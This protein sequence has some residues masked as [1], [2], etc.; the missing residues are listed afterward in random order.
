[1]TIFPRYFGNN[2]FIL[3]SIY[4][5]GLDI[6]ICVKLTLILSNYI[7]HIGMKLKVKNLIKLLKEWYKKGEYPAKTIL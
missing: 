5:I 2:L 1:M 4:L 7:T 6:D 3:F